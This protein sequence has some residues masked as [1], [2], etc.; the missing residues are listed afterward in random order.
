MKRLN[1]L[2]FALPLL[3]VVNVICAQSLVLSQRT[4]SQTA[5]VIADNSTQPTSKAAKELQ[6]YIKKTLSIDVPITNNG[7]AKNQII[8]GQGD[9]IKSMAP[10]VN[11]S[12]LGTDGYT[13]LT[14][15]TK[16]IIA[17]GSGKG[18]LFGVY[19]LL[20]KYFGC[21]M[22]TAD[23][24]KI[25]KRSSLTIPAVN[26]TEIPTLILRDVFYLGAMDSS[27]S[28]WHK[29]I[30][31]RSTNSSLFG[32]FAHTGFQIM[33]PKQYFNTHPEYYS[34]VKGKRQP[35]QL[36]PTNKDVY[37]ILLGWL[38]AKIK[39]QPQYNYWSVSV[40]DNGSYCECDKCLPV[41]NNTKTPGG[42]TIALANNLAQNF[43]NENISA[44]AY[45]YTRNPP[46]NMK[47]APN[48]NIMYCPQPK[49]YVS[50]YQG[51]DYAEMHNQF[52]GWQKLTKNIFVWDYVIDY[53]ALESIHP[54][55]LILKPNLQYFVNKG[56]KGYFAEG[57]IFPDGEFAELRAYLLSKLTWDPNLDDN[58]VIDDFLQGFY[59][60]AAPS[61]K[62][63]IQLTSSQ[64]TGNNKLTESM[65]NNYDDLFDA[66]MNSVK[67]QPV[68]LKRVQKER[69]PLQ[70]SAVQAYLDEASKDPDQFFNNTQKYN[71]F[72]TH[73]EGFLTSVKQCGIKRLV[74]N[75]NNLPLYQFYSD[76]KNKMSTL[77]S[78]SLMKK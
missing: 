33:P 54:N 13:I 27:Y 37:N 71:N 51:D 40:E 7:N 67:N 58:A 35:L 59:G 76:W 5:I 1:F 43:P 64:L 2:F 52:D 66:A 32:I 12:K 24:M 19:T 49:N 61:L 47:L 18:P 42:P 26:L 53:S 34:L 60:D 73:L 57:N 3:L 78:K 4:A 39:N 9:Y 29:L 45:S 70:Y 68:Y 11:T 50:S 48:L 10:E 72:N 41:I 46:Q 55:L 23:V 75:E 77:K 28:D 15:G 65:I 14:K 56:I 16:L 62:R 74:H 20:E 25:P 69:I 31:A 8:I 44:L 17:G 30:H 21:R 22:Y 6:K 38:N 63:Y 36:D